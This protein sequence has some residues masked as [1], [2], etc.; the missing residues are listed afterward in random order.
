MRT[1]LNWKSIITVVSVLVLVGCEVFVLALATAW[2]IA[3]LLELDNLVTYTLMAVFAV[4]G[5]VPLLKLTRMAFAVEPI[6]G[7][8]R[9]D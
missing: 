5:A 8:S 1:P 2:A 3:G 7:Q 9:I 6:R 4:L